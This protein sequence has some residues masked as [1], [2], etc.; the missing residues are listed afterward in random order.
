MY[1]SAEKAMRHAILIS[2]IA[3][4]AACGHAAEPVAPATPANMAPAAVT[5]DP[6]FDCYHANSAWG[7]TLA[8]KVI[9]AEGKILSY[10]KHGKAWLPALVKDGDAV[11]LTAADLRA[12]FAD[13]KDAG[14]VDAKAL[15]D[16]SALI[17]KAAEGKLTRTDTGTRDAGS[18]T[19]HAYIH[20]EAQ[21][22]YR[23]IEL[24]SDGGVS[25]MHVAN[26]AAEAQA[27]LN[28]LKSVGVAN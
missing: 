16:N 23:D 13:A 17:A 19:C 2:A 18:S 26:S 25:D 1:Q 6:V 15:A 5:L 24:G 10:G 20:D 9:D 21:R 12:K 22:R 3:A 8:G 11:Y 14:N 28:W 7:Y 27:L 4:I